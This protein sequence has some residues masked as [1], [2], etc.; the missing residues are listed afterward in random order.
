ML[1][2]PWVVSVVLIAVCLLL[3]LREWI[4]GR[5]LP[6]AN[7]ERGIAFFH[8]GLLVG[9]S[10]LVGYGTMMLFRHAEAL[11][12]YIPPYPG[13]RYAPER[14]ALS[15]L[16]QWIF[17]T[18]DQPDQIV[19][20][21]ET[22]ARDLGYTLNHDRASTTDRLYFERDDARIFLTVENEGAVRVLYYSIAGSVRVVETR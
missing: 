15:E 21:Y 14:E 7:P 20:N 9:L 12:S 2:F 3:A 13:A 1:Q 22:Y 18:E 5:D 19:A 6:V 8:A 4:E 11:S 17:V 10:L 16:A